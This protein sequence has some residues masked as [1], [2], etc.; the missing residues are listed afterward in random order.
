MPKRTRS[1]SPSRQQELF[2]PLA[3]KPKLIRHPPGQTHRHRIFVAL[4]PDRRTA[5]RAYGIGENMR[6]EC[7]LAVRLR[8]LDILHVTLCFI[9]EYARTPETTLFSASEAL[10]RIVAPRFEIRL[11]H[12]VDFN[13]AQGKRAL[14]L[15]SSQPNGALAFLQ[16]QVID[17]LFEAGVIK[18][19]PKT[20]EAHMTVF[21]HPDET[22][23][24]TRWLEKPI[25]WKVADFQL[26]ES[27][28]GETRYEHHDI[29]P[30]SIARK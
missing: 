16:Q 14:V 29:W 1:G 4:M 6:H 21:Y 13:L 25:V 7:G 20:F 10:S 27:F 3:G 5:A 22:S 19:R 23:I 11:D 24:E 8:P 30:L 9:G 28:Y 17:V 15:C 12:T 18:T 2:A 26:I